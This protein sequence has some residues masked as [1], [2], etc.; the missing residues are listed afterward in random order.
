[1]WIPGDEY[2]IVSGEKWL[3]EIMTY[4]MTENIFPCSS[5]DKKAPQIQY[6]WKSDGEFQFQCK[7]CSILC[8]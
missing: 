7:D 5:T 2:Q 4:I 3:T 1:M 8:V 6:K